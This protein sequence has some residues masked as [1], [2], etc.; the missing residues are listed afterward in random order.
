MTLVANIF[1]AHFWLKEELSSRD[2]I[3][4]VLILAGAA[5]AVAFG[6]KTE[7]SYTIS[8]LKDNFKQTAFVVYIIATSGLAVLA[9]LLV[10]RA[11]PIRQ[12]ILELR[13]KI[14]EMRESSAPDVQQVIDWEKETEMKFRSYRKYE[15]LHPF[16][17]CFL[18]GFGGSLVLVLAKCAAEL[19]RFSTGGD[20]QFTDPV[21][22]LFVVGMFAAIIFETHMLATGL[23]YFD[24]LYVVPVFQCFFVTLGAAAGGV[25][26][27]E[28]SR[29]SALQ[30]I[31]FP[32][33]VLTTLGG[34]YLLSTRKM[35][36]D[37]EQLAAMQGG[38]LA[39]RR[40]KRAERGE[41]GSARSQ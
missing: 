1:F 2:I 13:K 31:L 15:R 30:T 21:S 18:A 36:A 10:K 20:N 9:L 23:R 27:G 16:C 17:Y 35:S 41:P 32:I 38:Y 40:R 26:F 6:D 19:V 37:Q 39:P 24:A 33:G 28:F 34:V 8:I 5:M 12:E 29:F 7:V 14:Q 3:G 25:F 4:T 11:Q 22:T